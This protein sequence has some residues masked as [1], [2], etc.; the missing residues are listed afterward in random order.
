V[1]I[2][3]VLSSRYEYL[4]SRIEFEKALAIDPDDLASNLGYAV[5]LSVTGYQRER[6]ERLRHVLALDPQL[7]NALG[8]IRWS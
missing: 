1:A 2:T 8:V 5:H 4:A 6:V 3:H 7:P